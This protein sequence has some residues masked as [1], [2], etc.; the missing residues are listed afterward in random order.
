MKPHGSY[1]SFLQCRAVKKKKIRTFFQPLSIVWEKRELRLPS[2]SLLRFFS[3]F[4]ELSEEQ[5][6]KKLRRQKKRMRTRALMVGVFT[7]SSQLCPERASLSQRIKGVKP[8]D[9]QKL[10]D[11]H[12]RSVQT[13]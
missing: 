13:T 2:S 5:H 1:P 3:H 12:T 4:G 7:K 11:W 10:A 8:T 6:S 9:P